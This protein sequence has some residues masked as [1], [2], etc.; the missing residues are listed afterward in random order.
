[1]LG[2]PTLP[3]ITGDGRLL[4][5]GLPAPGA[6]VPERYPAALL[7]GE[8][9]FSRRVEVERLAADGP[10]AGFSEEGR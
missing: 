4:T 7:D 5:G 9:P 6:L 8:N 10:K 3:H 2:I 1:M